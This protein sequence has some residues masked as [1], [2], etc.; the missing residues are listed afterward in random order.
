[1]RG[2]SEGVLSWYD[3]KRNAMQYCNMNYPIT[4]LLPSGNTV[5]QCTPPLPSALGKGKVLGSVFTLLQF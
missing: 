2:T 3:E 1:M 4:N 5:V